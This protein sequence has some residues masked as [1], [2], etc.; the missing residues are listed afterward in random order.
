MIII[1]V[2]DLFRPSDFFSFFSEVGKLA[3]IEKGIAPPAIT[4]TDD[5]PR[6]R[7]GVPI[8]T[9]F[10]FSQKGLD[11]PTVSD[12]FSHCQIERKLDLTQPNIHS[13]AQMK[14]DP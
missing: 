8:T 6:T 14:T 3:V 10:K 1:I 11:S 7:N 13:V 4:A 2:D 12:G 5:L 9:P